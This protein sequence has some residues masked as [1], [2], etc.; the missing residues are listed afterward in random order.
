MFDFLGAGI[1]AI[2]GTVS[3]LATVALLHCLFPHVGDVSYLHAALVALGCSASERLI[4]FK[5]GI[6]SQFAP[7]KREWQRE[8]RMP[9]AR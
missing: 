6:G 9:P 7:L 1:G 5:C 3:G 4:S 2:V 8:V